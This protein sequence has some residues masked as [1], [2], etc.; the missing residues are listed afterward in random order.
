MSNLFKELKR[1][2]VVRVAV[3][4]LVIG[5]LVMQVADTLIPVLGLPESSAKF[6]FL[7]IAIGFIPTLLFSWWMAVWVWRHKIA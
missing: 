4:Y 5:W 1:R 7:I 6:L 2:N 3:A